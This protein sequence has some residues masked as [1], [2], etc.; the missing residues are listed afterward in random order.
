MQA[1][2][3]YIINLKRN[4]ERKLFMQ[5]QLDALGLKYSF[6]DVDAIDKYELESKTYRNRIAKLLDID[7][8]VL[9]RKYDALMSSAKN[10]AEKS[11]YSGAIATMLSHIQI[12]NSMVKNDIAAACILEDDATLL[13][14][15]PEILRNA[16]ELEWDILMIASLSVALTSQLSHQLTSLDDNLIQLNCTKDMVLLRKANTF[17]RKIVIPIFNKDLLLISKKTENLYAAKKQKHRLEYWLKE[18]GINARLRPEQSEIFAKILQEHDTKYTE[19]IKTIAPNNHQLSLIETALYR[20]KIYTLTQL[21]ALPDKHSLELITKHHCIA[22]LR[23]KAVSTTAYMLKQSAAMKWKQQALAENSMKID[24]IPW[25]LYRNE[26]VKLRLITPPCVTATY[27]YIK[28][29]TRRG[30]I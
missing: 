19:I 18:Y 1:I 16:A 23:A 24:E 5:R 30:A 11:G 29:S 22:K 7:E 12:Y 27:R 26:Q 20:H 21:G 15:F 28:Y 25:Q 10:E 3:I 4:P 13:P 9:E 6:V 17:W 8:T 14:T 2:P